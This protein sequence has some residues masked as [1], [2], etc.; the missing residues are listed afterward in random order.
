MTRNELQKDMEARTAQAQ[1]MLGDPA[2]AEEF[3]ALTDK[4]AVI[5]DQLRAIDKAEAEVRAMKDAEKNMPSPAISDTDGWKGVRNQLLKAIESGR[6]S[7][8]DISS[9][10]RR[11]L[12]SGGTGTNTAPGIVRDLVDGGKLRP[13]VST[14]LGKNASTVVPVM[15]PTLALP[16]G[17]VPG[18]LGT[19]SDAT[20]ALA[21]RALTLTAWYSTIQVSMGALLSSD[22]ERE[23]PAAFSDAFG[24]AIDRAI[25]AGG[26]AGQ[27]ARGVFPVDANGVPAGSNLACASGTVALGGP[28]FGDYVNLILTLL[29]L[30]GDTNS[31]RIVVNPVIFRAALNQAAAGFD[32]MKQE[33]LMKGTV[34]GVPVVFSSYAPVVTTNGSRTAV[35]GYF[36]HYALAIAQEITVDQIKTVGSDNVTFQAFMYM[37]GTPLLGG[38]FRALT[39]TT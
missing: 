7:S 29:A 20:A 39:Q 32:P 12:V 38:S 9:I 31:L 8:I 21:G 35:G 23:L 13:L 24:G 37:M 22:I 5:G 16:V 33:F 27:D 3:K 18:A 34:L 26:G 36:K 6:R 25:V 19:A 10:E 4:V 28:G 14:F 1:T 17:T 11:A 30:G 15:S 2:K